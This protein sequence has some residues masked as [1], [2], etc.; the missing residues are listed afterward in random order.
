MSEAAPI[1]V[2][3]VEHHHISLEGVRL[4]IE[5][6]RDMTVVG[7]RASG[8]EALSLANDVKPDVVVTNLSLP[9]L[10]GIALAQRLAV[11]APSTRVIILSSDEDRKHVQRALQ[12]GARGYVLKQSGVH[13]LLNAIR[14]VVARG[15]YLDPT[16]VQGSPVAGPPA[17]STPGDTAQRVDPQLS[18]REAEVLRFIARGYTNKEIAGQLSVTTKT[19]ETYK[20]R[21]LEKLDLKTRPQIVQYAASQGWLTGW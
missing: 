18:E 21:A 17:P 6:T 3:L 7:M 10:D 20:A 5:E 14:T 19:I 8:M 11:E 1:S 15:T 16:I 4:L 2:L 13:S 9:D 12:S